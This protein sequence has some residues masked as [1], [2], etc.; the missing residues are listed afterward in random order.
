MGKRKSKTMSLE[1]LK[2]MLARAKQQVQQLVE[3]RAGL[4]ARVA[5]IDGDVAA[6]TGTKKRPATTVPAG[7]QAGKSGPEPTPKKRGR[8]KMTLADHVAK[9]L[10][11]ATKPMSPEQIGE[12][13]RKKGAS[14]SKSLATQVGQILAGEKVAVKK[15]GRGQYVAASKE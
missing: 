13:L 3:E 1:E 7:P 9:I 12:A 11:A 10:Q 2:G 8:K 15:L 4:V 5:E 6:L 14:T